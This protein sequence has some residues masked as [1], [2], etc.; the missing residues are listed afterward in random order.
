MTFAQKAIA[1][2]MSVVLAFGLSPIGQVKAYAETGEQPAQQEQALQTQDDSTTATTTWKDNFKVSLSKDPIIYKGYSKDGAASGGTLTNPVAAYATNAATATNG[3]R[4]PAAGAD[5]LLGSFI[6]VYALSGKAATIATPGTKV[7]SDLLLANGSDTAA[8]NKVTA[9]F[10]GYEY[11]QNGKAV[12][13]VRDA[14]DYTLVLYGPG[15]Y[16]D[17]TI[18]LNFTVEKFDLSSLDG[19]SASLTDAQKQA[20]G[21]EYITAQPQTATGKYTGSSESVTFPATTPSV[22]IAGSNASVTT[23]DYVFYLEPTD[24]DVTPPTVLGRGN[25]PVSIT[26]KGKNVEGTVALS[27]VNVGFGE[28]DANGALTVNGEATSSKEITLSGTD[29]TP[30]EAAPDPVADGLVKFGDTE[31]KEGT[32]FEAYYFDTIANARTAATAARTS[33]AVSGTGLQ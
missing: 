29:A 30:S 9:Y 26:G 18:E 33:G 19:T 6:K 10:S 24:F 20:A 25:T 4:T 32:D 31:L 16:S 13:E 5:D 11:Q 17:E 2:G 1:T 28:F 3:M 22:T 21:T 7:T 23:D 8:A 12:K 15:I 27:D 14:G